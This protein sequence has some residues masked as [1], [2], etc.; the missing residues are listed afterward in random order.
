MKERTKAC[1][2]LCA[3]Q[4]NIKIIKQIAPDSKILAMVKSNAYGHGLVAVAKSLVEADGF[5]VACLSEAM[6]LR[7]NGILAPIVIMSGVYSDE[8][9]QFAQ[10]YNFQIV[11]HDASQLKLL[12][13]CHLHRP[14]TVWLKID[15]GMHRLGFSPENFLFSLRELLGNEKINKSITLITH[16]ADA[17][18][19]Y[20]ATTSRQLE[21]FQKYTGHL[22]FPKSIAN[23]AG[24]LSWP[25]AIADWNRPGIC[26]Y[27]ISP[28]LDKVGADYGLIPVMTLKSKIVAIREVNAGEAIGYGSTWVCRK[29][30]LIGVVAIGYGDGYPRHAPSGTPTL[31]HQQI[32]PLV[33]R[34]SMDLL[35]VDLEA[36]PQAV[37]GD[38]V[39][40]WGNGLPAEIVAKFA[41]TIAYQLI[42]NVTQRV[43]FDYQ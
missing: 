3:L 18:D 41:G 38:E 35:T 28:I 31:I 14:L 4:H 32:C 22:N 43:V 39:I 36:C 33:G 13:N 6:T 2:D 24:I 25:S 42:C 40:L 34:I 23:S 8:E 29:K 7:E 37:V 26:L 17:D 15:T 11:V 27:G 21:V 10:G 12:R 1:I 19:L 30:M 9:I 20:K 5:G 16:L